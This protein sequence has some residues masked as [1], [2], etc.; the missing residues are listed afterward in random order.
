MNTD[1]KTKLK[2]FA[3]SSNW[4]MLLMNPLD[5]QKWEVFMA[6]AKASPVDIADGEVYG[7]IKGITTNPC[8]DDIAGRMEY[9]CRKGKQ[10]RIKH[11]ISGV[12]E[13]MKGLFGLTCLMMPLM[14]LAD[15]S[16]SD[17]KVFSGCPWKEVVIGYTI[18]GI[19]AETDIIRL[20]ATDKSANKTYTAQSLTGAVLTE[21][22]HVLRWNAAAEGAKFSSV[23]VVFSVS[24]FDTV[25]SVQLWT[26]G[27]YWAECNVGAAKP[28]EYGYYFWWGDTVGYK[29]SA[30]NYGWVSVK[31]GK[32][33]SFSS[34]NC[35]TYGKNISQLKSE[36]YIDETGNLVAAYDAAT[37][38]LGKQWRMPTDAEC[39]ALISNCTIKWTTRNGVSGLLITGK[40]TYASKSIFLP[41]AGSGCDDY[42]DCLGTLG[43][44]WVSTPN[45]NNSGYSWVLGFDFDS[46]S[47]Q[48]S[49]GDRYRARSVRPVLEFAQ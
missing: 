36:K 2:E 23:N 12:K 19:A 5:E 20:V 3:A 41:S 14:A 44:Y 47:V 27:P 43:E 29:R 25:G 35:P 46:H 31:S 10:G 37:A 18:T 16:V 48:R 32:G 8:P 11:F 21:G 33:F 34:R 9:M 40:G 45:S 42:H 28:E 17:V 49:N 7:V 4:S 39:D 22:R 26:N 13:A 1:Q 30:S 6:A 38:H 24:I 15:I